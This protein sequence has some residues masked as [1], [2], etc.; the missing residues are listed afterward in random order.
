MD[1]STQ[2]A[3]RTTDT[4]GTL[5]ELLEPTSRAIAVAHDAH[6]RESLAAVI[7]ERRGFLGRLTRSSR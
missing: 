4:K 6:L 7:W 3:D 5:G 1:E 2:T